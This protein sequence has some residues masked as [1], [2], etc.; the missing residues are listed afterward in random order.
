MNEG[1]F[2]DALNVAKEVGSG[3]YYGLGV[4]KKVDNAV[5]DW[6]NG[7]IANQTGWKIPNYTMFPGTGGQQ[8]Y[9]RKQQAQQQAKNN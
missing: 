7:W 4:N 6:N 2:D 8:A 9:A 1:W 3:L 5:N